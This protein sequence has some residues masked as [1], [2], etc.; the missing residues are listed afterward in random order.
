[1]SEY[2]V[3]QTTS[4]AGVLHEHAIILLQN[5]FEPAADQFLLYEDPRWRCSLFLHYKT[6][7]GR[8]I[9]LIARLSED[10]LIPPAAISLSYLSQAVHTKYSVSAGEIRTYHH[11]FYKASLNPFPQHLKADSFEIAGNRYR[12]MGLA[13]MERDEEIMGKDGDIVEY[14]KE[15]QSQSQV[16]MPHS[17]RLQHAVRG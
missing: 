9:L 15:L 7:T 17:C 12:W 4:P 1:M 16:R 3:F 2:P 8:D 14:V 6:S 11:R 5:T 13:E 10:L